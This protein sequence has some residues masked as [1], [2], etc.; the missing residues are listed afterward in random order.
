MAWHGM[1][2]HGM[3][4]YGMVWYGMVWYGL[5]CIVNYTILLLYYT[6]IALR[7]LFCVF[8]RVKDHPALPHYSQRLKNKCAR[9][10]ALD[11]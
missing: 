8:R 4:W 10:A 6:I 1:A 9:Q 3:A 5:V 2:W 11:K 7:Q